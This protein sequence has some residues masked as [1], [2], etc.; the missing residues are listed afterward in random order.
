VLA[1]VAASIAKIL[2]LV[3]LAVMVISFAIRALRGQSVV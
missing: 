3:F 2:F 1:S